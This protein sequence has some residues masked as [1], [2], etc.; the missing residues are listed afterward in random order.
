MAREL[1]PTGIAGLDELTGG[2]LPTGHCILL[3]GGPGSGK[4][5]LANQFM[6]KGAVDYGETGLYVTLDE[7]PVHLK[8]HMNSF[9]W[10]LDKLEKEKKIVIVDASPIRNMPTELRLSGLNIASRE[11]N[12][13]ALIE[14]IKRSAKKIN[15]KR[16]V[17]DPIT[18]LIIHYQTAS[19]RHYAV[20][21]LVQA[22]SDTGCTS[23][24]I[25]D[26]RPSILERGFQFEEYITQGVIL[27]QSTKKERQLIRALQIEKMRGI[28]HDTQ[29]RP[30]QITDKGIEVFP[31]E[32]VL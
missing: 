6:Y 22:M 13:P 25:T 11:F 29:L 4:T 31:K 18:A 2:G 24:I 27:L 21:D 10:D 3:C 20:V 19:E 7:N 8:H 32:V 30:Y 28:P 12:M 14:T 17:I 9:G 16:L 15:A 5:I 23:I 1:T 26:L